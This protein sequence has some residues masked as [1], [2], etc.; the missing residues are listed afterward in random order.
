MLIEGFQKSF[1]ELNLVLKIQMD[2]RHRLGSEHP[3]WEKPL[4]DQEPEKLSYLC[5]KLNAG[6]EAERTS[7]SPH[8]FL[9]PLFQ[10]RKTKLIFRFFFFKITI[11]R[12]I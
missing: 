12:F 6:E 10:T 11:R 9:F 7:K 2:D 5:E 3:I 8:T 1:R 4:L